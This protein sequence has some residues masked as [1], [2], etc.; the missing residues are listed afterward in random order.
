[1]LVPSDPS[2]LCILL[3]S[4]VVIDLIE[5]EEGLDRNTLRTFG[6]GSMFKRATIHRV[7]DILHVFEDHG[8]HLGGHVLLELAFRFDCISV[9]NVKGVCHILTLLMIM[10]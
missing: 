8:V 5:A 2:L 9:Q 10:L 3:H 4:S 1:M 6:I 7:V